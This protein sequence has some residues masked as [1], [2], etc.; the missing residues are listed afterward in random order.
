MKTQKMIDWQYVLGLLML[1]VV[2]VALLLL[3]GYIQGFIHYDPRYFTP[4]YVDR[5]QNVD[6][7]IT[8]LEQALQNGDAGL[9]AEVRGTRST[10]GNLKP[11]PNLVFSILGE[12]GE[13]YQD[14]LFAD[15]VTYHRFM[16]HL[17]KVKNRYVVVPENLYYYVDSGR[18]TR[19]FLPIAM[20]WWLG[21][22]LFT[23]GMWVYRYMEVLRQ[24]MWGGGAPR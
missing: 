17:K 10:P 16:M 18:W 1:P 8:N 20:I 19:T 2:I 3:I 9:L 23:A 15:R 5:Y 6:A 24:K 4:E 14:Y 12:Q 11:A 7:V 22:I 21:V 13:K